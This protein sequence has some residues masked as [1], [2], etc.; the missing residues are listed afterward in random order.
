LSAL[1][2]AD[3]ELLIVATD[4]EVDWP[5]ELYGRRWEIETLFSCLKSR[6]FNFEDTH[7]TKPE[8]I[9]KLVALLTIGFCW[10]YKTGE[11]R[12]EQKAIKIKKHGRKEISYFRYGLDLLRDVALNAGRNTVVLFE[13]VIGFLNLEFPPRELT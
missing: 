6:G 10:A 5:I 2:L 11:W 4:K 13:Q 9:A 12:H 3:G 8:R 1:R 7:I